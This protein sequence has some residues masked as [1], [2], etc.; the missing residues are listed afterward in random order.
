MLCCGPEFGVGDVHSEQSVLR[1]AKKAEIQEQVQKY[2]GSER[3]VRTIQEG[4]IRT[5]V[6]K[7]N[8]KCI[9]RGQ[10]FSADVPYAALSTEECR[11]VELQPTCRLKDPLLPLTVQKRLSIHPATPNQ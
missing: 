7:E 3:N 9:N 5:N 2:F 11:V 6:L 1:S 8:T 4:E 10:K